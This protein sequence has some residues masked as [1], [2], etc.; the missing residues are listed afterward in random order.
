MKPGIP[1]RQ[2]YGTYTLHGH[3]K[4]VELPVTITT[5]NGALQLTGSMMFNLSDYDV[6]VPAVLVNDPITFT[7]ELTAKH[8][9][10]SGN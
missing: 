7:V 4:T 8:L 10:E 6:H 1:C 5:G 2:T 9:S 3:P